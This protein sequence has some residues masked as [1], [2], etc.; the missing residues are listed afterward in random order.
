MLPAFGNPNDLTEIEGRLVES[1]D[2]VSLLFSRACVLDMLGRNNE[3]R[4]A[5]IEVIKRD[6]THIGALGNL[7]TLLY[8]AGYRNA[9]RL[10]YNEALRHHPRDLR[11]LINLA[12]AL[13]EN[14]E[15]PL[16]RNLYERALEV[17]PQS[18]PAHQGLS[19][20]LGRLGQH[21]LAEE[22][23]RAGFEA[24]RNCFVNATIKHVP[25]AIR[26]KTPRRRRAPMVR[27][28]IAQPTAPN[29]SWAMDFMHDVLA[30]GTKIR[31]LTIVDT[32]SRESIALELDYGFKSPQVVEVLRRAVAQ[33][34][35]PER[36]Y[37]DNGPEFISLHLDQWAYWTRVKLAFSRPG[38]PSD[39]AF[40]ESFNNR[41]R[42]ELLNPNWFRSLDDAR[43]QAAAWRIDYNTN[44]PHSSLGDLAP[45]E[46]ARRASN[47]TSQA[48]ISGAPAD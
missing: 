16:S 6:G 15:L 44:H 31:L 21:A 30:D 14:D 9:A 7:G 41:V 45:E 37:C 24:M 13:L 2:D 18:A 8:N 12:N 3:A 19:H 36:I 27:E 33:R 23:R 22:H 28:A 48:A 43:L 1:P 32:F 35:A 26:T 29:Q 25:E 11:T 38:R 34:G 47:L 10:T 17:D 5:Y 39:N 4:D 42:Q 20:V 40:C 46:F